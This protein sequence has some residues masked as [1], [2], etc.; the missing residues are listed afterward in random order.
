M[1]KGTLAKIDYSLCDNCGICVTKCPVKT[2]K[3]Y[4]DR[5]E[6]AAS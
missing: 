4:E 2:I 1:D 5:V 6:V 3:S